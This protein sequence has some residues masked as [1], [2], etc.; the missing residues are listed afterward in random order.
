MNQ[1]L[2]EILVCPSCKGPLSY[3]KNNAHN[4]HPE[5]WCRAEKLAYPIID[6]IPVMLLEQARNLSL[7]ELDQ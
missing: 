5:L 1:S 4:N 7:E 6:S 3:Q 2:L